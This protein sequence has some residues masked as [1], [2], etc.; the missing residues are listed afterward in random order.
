MTLSLNEIAALSLKAAR[1]VGYDWG[2]AEEAGRAVR[3]LA[4]RD[5]SG[6]DALCALLDHVEAGPPTRDGDPPGPGGA[7]CPI[8]LGC[9]IADGCRGRDAGRRVAGPVVAPLLLLPFAAWAASLARRSYTV[10]WGCGSARI[11]A[12]GACRL[13]G[14]RPANG[15]DHVTVTIDVGATP[16][17]VDP[18]PVGFRARVPPETVARLA[19]YAGRTYA[20][21]TEASR[22]AGAGAGL[23][24]N[25]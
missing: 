23:S 18:L 2:M 7:G 24:D 13:D 4:A 15:P 1:G 3:W 10:A 20:P 11:D 16:E 8:A 5:L 6:A 25:D 14:R 12:G 9:R 22:I 21:A 17:A 19:A